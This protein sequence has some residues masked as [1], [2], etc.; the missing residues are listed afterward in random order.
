LIQGTISVVIQALIIVGLALIVGATFPG[1]PGGV[2]VL[3]VCASLLGFGFGALSN[4]LALLARREETLIAVLQFLMLPLTFLST[5]FM[6]KD[7]VPG[8]I[9][10]ICAVNP[11]D[12]AI[13]AGRSAVSNDVDWGLV[14]SRSGYLLVFAIVSVYFATRAFRSY[15]RQV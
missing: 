6:Q 11:V 12:W 3:I 7:L 1:G 4:G 14:L 15:Q 10:T 5:A 13:T 2:L 9:K 8:W